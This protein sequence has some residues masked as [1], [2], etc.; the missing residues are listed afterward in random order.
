MHVS[1]RESTAEAPPRA[2]WP[3]LAV[4]GMESFVLATSTVSRRSNIGLATR[5]SRRSL[6]RW[7]LDLEEHDKSSSCSSLRGNNWSVLDGDMPQNWRRSGQDCRVEGQS[8]GDDGGGPA[9]QIDVTAVEALGGTRARA[10][11]GPVCLRAGAFYPP[12]PMKRCCC[13]CFS[14]CPHQHHPIV[15]LTLAT[16]Q[17]LN[18]AVPCPQLSATPSSRTRSSKKAVSRSACRRVP[19]AAARPFS[20]S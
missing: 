6:S 10:T 9:I 20:S 1:P 19:L 3:A 8:L 15:D 14:C 11:E 12:P 7:P 16:C 2:L 17:P 13:C 5:L 18:P 4:A